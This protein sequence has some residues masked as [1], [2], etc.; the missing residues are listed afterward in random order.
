MDI[1]LLKLPEA[2]VLHFTY[3]VPSTDH[4]NVF[5]TFNRAVPIRPVTL[6]HNNGWSQCKSY[7]HDASWEPSLRIICS[8][9]IDVLLLQVPSSKCDHYSIIRTNPLNLH[10]LAF[11]IVTVD[12]SWICVYNICFIESVFLYILS[13]TEETIPLDSVPNPALSYCI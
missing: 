8:L 1:P 13:Y 10:L 4:L 11:L 7:M 12:A 3:L 5:T 6:I 2:T 9:E